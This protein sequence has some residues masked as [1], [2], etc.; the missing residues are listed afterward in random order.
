[1]LILKKI[2]EYLYILWQGWKRIFSYPKDVLPVN[3]KI[4]YNA[5][6][7]DKRGEHIGELSDWQ[8]ERAHLIERVVGGRELSIVTDIGCGD[9]GILKY[10]KEH[11]A[12]ER[13]IGIDT[14]AFALEQ[15]SKFGIE[16]IQA[17]IRNIEMLRNIPRSDYILLLEVLEHIPNAE[18]MLAF[19]YSKSSKGVF[20]S[21]PN[22]GYFPY[23]LRLLFGK[24]P[25]QWRLYPNE[26]VRF[27][28][29]C[30]LKWWLKALRIGQYEIRYYKGISLLNK[31]WPS[32]FASGFFVHIK[33]EK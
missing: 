28:T 16:T 31:I 17:D 33:K 29:R 11:I 4:D 15:A 27:W 8:L 21:F 19:A 25:A 32:M 9:G 30:D 12:V 14:S 13:V 10:I 2:K 18:E 5:Y 20:F 3:G 6:W 7:Q 1:M 23:R 24:F 22:S 26:H